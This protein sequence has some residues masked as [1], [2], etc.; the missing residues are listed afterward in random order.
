[1]WGHTVRVLGAA[2]IPTL[3]YQMVEGSN[4]G[5]ETLPAALAKAYRNN[6]QLNAQRAFVRQTDEQ[7]PL[8]QSGYRPQIAATASGG[9]QQ[10]DSR[11]RATPGGSLRNGATTQ[12]GSVGVVGT[13]TLFDGF[14]TDNQ[15]LAAQGNVQGAR[16]MLRLMTQQ[17]LLDATGAYMDI[18]RDAAIAQL[19]GRNVEMLQEQLRHTRERLAVREVTQTDVSQAESRLAAARWQR[20]AAESAVNAS[21]AAYRRVIGENADNKLTPGTPVDRLSPRTLDEAVAVGRAKNPSVTAAQ[22]GIDVA[23]VQVKIAEGALYPTAQL[24]GTVQHAWNPA[25]QLDRQFGAGVF[26]TLSVPIYQGGA[27]Y[28]TIRQ[29]KEALDQKRLDLDRVR[30]LVRA[31]IVE[32]WGQLLAARSQIEAA[33]AQVAAAEAALNGVI[34][35]ARAGQRTTLDVLNAQQELVSARVTLVATQRDRVVGSYAL[36]SAVGRLAPD[37]LGLPTEIYDPQVHYQQ[38][39]SK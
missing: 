11:F 3:T 10:T 39:R 2:A 29:S 26:V 34:Q 21:R 17:I 36:L 24:Q 22:A 14:R 5:A 31:G 4:A 18:L 38:V 20:L 13:Q 37:A 32:S 33:Q 8:A 9:V 30:D 27:E 23:A 19:Q 16:E 25:P 28:A 6:P 1:M 12:G 35:E 7:V 15:V